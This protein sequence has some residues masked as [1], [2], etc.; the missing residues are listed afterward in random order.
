MIEFYEILATT[1]NLEYGNILLATS[2]KSQLQAVIDND[3]PF[4][5]NNTDL[6]KICLLDSD[7]GVIQDIIQ[8]LGIEFYRFLAALAALYLPLVE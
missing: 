5:T 6:V 7:C 1:L 8:D 2:T 3:W 4:F